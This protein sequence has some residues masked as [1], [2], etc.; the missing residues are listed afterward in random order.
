MSMYEEQGS[1]EV[2]V[3]THEDS[4]ERR[5]GISLPDGTIILLNIEQ[6]E[7]VINSLTDLLK[8][9]KTQPYR[10]VGTIQ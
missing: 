10:A 5:I 9:I 2:G 8:V 3:M 4:G 6:S 1:I 7:D